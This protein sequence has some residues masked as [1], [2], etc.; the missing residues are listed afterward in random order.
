MPALEQARAELGELDKSDVTEIRSFVKP[1]RPV[2][3]VSE[4]ICVFKGSIEVSWKAA[5]GMMADANFLQ[6]LQTM[7]VDAIG[8]KQLASVKERLD[9]SKVTMQQMQ[10]VSRAGAGFLR[11]V[12]AVMGYCEVLKDVRPKRDKVAKLEKSLAQNE[13]DLELIKS[14]LT[15]LEEEIKKLNGEYSTAKAERMALQ[16]ETAVMERRL[17]AADTLINGLSC[18]SVRWEVQ[19]ETLR[20]ERRRLVGDCLL[21]A[22]FLT[23]AGAFSH[24]LRNHMLHDDWVPDLQNREILLTEP[25]NVVHLL[26][27]K[28][29]VANWKDAGLS[30]DDLSIQ[31]GILTTRVSRFPL[32][33]DPQQQTLKWIKRLEGNNNLRV[34]TFNDPDFLKSLELSIK[35]GTPFLFEDVGDHIDPII[36]NVLSKNVLEDRN[37]YF[38]MLGDKE[39]EYDWNFRLYL[40]TKLSNP[41]YGPKLF[42]NAVII[43]C[44]VT[45]EE[46]ENQLL[47][48]IVKHEQSSLEEKKT[49]LTR[50]KSENRRILKDLE[51][52]LLMNLT[53][54]TGSLLD[55]E[56]LISTVE[57]AK[58]RAIEAK[59]K[60][61]FA[62]KTSAEVKQLSNAYRPAAKRGALL[63][64]VLTDMA[65]INPMYQFALSTYIALFEDALHRSMPDTALGKRLDNI[66]SKL[67]EVVYNYGCT[68]FFER[69]KLL[70]SFQIS[71]KLQAEAGYISQAEVDF[72]TKGDTSAGMETEHCPIAWLTDTKWKDIRR[73]EE[74]LPSSFAGLSESLVANQKQWEEWFSLGSLECKP[75]PYFEKIS[76]FQKLC[77][78]RCFRVDRVCR[79]VEIFV[80][81][82]LGENLLALHMPNLSSI[83]QQSQPETPIVFIFSPGSDPTDGLKKFAENSLTL[84]ASTNLVFLSM[85]QDQESSA[86]KLFKTASSEGSWLVLQNCH[87]LL[88]W[89]PTLEKAIETTKQFHPKFRLW[90]TTEPSLDFPIGFLHRSLKVVIEPLVGLKRNLRS[91]FLEIPASKFTDYPYPAFSV[92]AYTLTFFHAVVQE[93]RQYGKL[94]WNIAYE[95]NL[96][97]FQASLTVIADQLE[98]SRGKSSLPWGSLRYLIEEIIYGGRVMDKFDQRVLNTYMNEY[99]GD[100]LFDTIQ[101]FHFFTNEEV[102]YT[103][104]PET[105]REGILRYIDTLPTNNS[106]EVLGM[107]VNAEIDSFTSKA[108]KLWSYLLALSHEDESGSSAVS[109]TTAQVTLT[110]EIAEKVLLSLPPT[111]DREAIRGALKE[112]LTPTAIVL[113]QELEHFNRLLLQMQSTLTHLKQAMSGEVALSSDLGEMATSLR[114]GRLP[115]LWRSLAPATKKSLAN[116]L[117]HFNR[118]TEQYKAWVASGEPIVIWLSGLHVPQSY[119]SAVAQ[120]VCRRNAWP[121]DKSIIVT[122]VTDYTDEEAVEDRSLAGCLLTGLFLEGASW[123]P[124]I[125]QLCPQ[126]PR[127]LIQP[128]PLLKVN[129]MESR[130]AKR[131]STLLTPVYVTSARAD[132]DGRGLVFEAD[133]AM[134]EESDANYWILQGVCLLLN[135]D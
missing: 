69:H 53:L 55:N 63:F 16:E 38:V 32:L 15:K 1:P 18:E 12:H 121:L 56:E 37:R 109:A 11:F 31:N 70:F 52:S 82:T 120:S 51:D 45:E 80:A 68:G 59:E 7:D 78:I 119:L 65:T 102:S 54:S 79:A 133:L 95:F 61:A 81:N 13:R 96:S 8:T 127:Q 91:T 58:A 47:G 106:P 90:L 64:F 131:H 74:I 92:L 110:I 122:T 14:E 73:L 105:S 20:E 103:L 5:K 94:G 4:C 83:Y 27:D 42:N 66:I 44:T 35:F 46:L 60:L 75:P 132:A 101:H 84:D 112:K 123:N 50:T 115:G 124:R 41:A 125:G 21:S 76:D 49:M 2:Q 108:H 129:V 93:R 116:W 114:N 104:P 23:Y 130:R 107:K 48:V 30:G 39:V 113:L 135:D 98:S 28:V 62:T 33:I 85:G 100:F 118:R 57:V 72:F 128:L 25:F 97:D 36:H 67:T 43:N 29:T 111:F 6:S 117:T 126:A 22:A 88:K 99:F 77:L 26:T 86:M 24:S 71:L 34:A 134:G 89:I 19:A 87:L 17:A 9:T 40:N 3:V 10:S